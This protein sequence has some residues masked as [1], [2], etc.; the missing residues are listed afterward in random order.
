[1]AGQ[2][3]PC[4]YAFTFA[5]VDVVTLNFQSVSDAGLMT[6]RLTLP[7]MTHTSGAPWAMRTVGVAG[8]G[9]PVG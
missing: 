2:S 4:A 1:V 9:D 6:W 7:S 8:S 5:A 3:A